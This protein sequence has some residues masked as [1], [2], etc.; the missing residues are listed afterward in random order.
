L[1]HGLRLFLFQTPEGRFLAQY[2]EGMHGLFD[3]PHAV[4]VHFPP[5][6]VRLL[7]YRTG[8]PCDEQTY[9]PVQMGVGCG[10][11]TPYPADLVQ[12]EPDLSY[13]DFRKA[14]RAGVVSEVR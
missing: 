8:I 2:W 4:T 3:R 10:G 5:G 11:H 14:M 1:P 9:G 13:E 6:S 12:A 7:N